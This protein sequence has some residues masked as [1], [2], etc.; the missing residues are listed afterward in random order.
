MIGPINLKGEN[1]CD[2]ITDGESSS[3]VGSSFTCVTDTVL[4]ALT[5]PKGSNTATLVGETIPAGYECFGTISALTVTSGIIQFYA[6]SEQTD[7]RN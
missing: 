7:S 3:F 6:E 4:S 2:F 1:G 5:M